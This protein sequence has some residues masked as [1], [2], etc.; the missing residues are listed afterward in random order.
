MLNEKSMIMIVCR[1]S[2]STIS[3][4]KLAL[5]DVP[6]T[7]FMQNIWKVSDFLFYVCD[8]CVW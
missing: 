8:M 2:H 3:V 5:I 7:Y 4:I 6:K 1:C